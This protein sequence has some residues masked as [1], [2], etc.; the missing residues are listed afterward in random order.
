MI[1]TF[2]HDK[3]ASL[4]PS[5]AKY[6]HSLPPQPPKDLEK[7]HENRKVTGSALTCKLKYPQKASMKKSL[8]RASLF[9]ATA[10]LFF[11]IENAEVL[12]VRLCYS[13][14]WVKHN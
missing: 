14:K 5:H 11:E 3:K 7:I 10:F 12:N 8:S 9:L 2:F 1:W 4:V 13:I 6:M